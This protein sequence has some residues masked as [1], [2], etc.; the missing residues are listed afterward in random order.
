MVLIL[1]SH[2]TEPA[3]IK[4]V[5]KHVFHNAKYVRK[6]L[7]F[8]FEMYP[9]TTEWCFLAENLICSFILSSEI[10]IIQFPWLKT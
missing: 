7:G 2:S 6:G 5:L 8:A 10:I 4:L 1:V 9:S 3:K